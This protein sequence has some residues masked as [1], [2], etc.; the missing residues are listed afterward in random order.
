LEDIEAREEEEALQRH[1]RQIEERHRRIHGGV[2]E[3]EEEVDEIID[4]DDDGLDDGRFDDYDIQEN[5][6]LQSYIDNDTHTLDQ[7]EGIMDKDIL[8]TPEEKKKA[9]DQLI[10][11]NYILQDVLRYIMTN[12]GDAS[13]ILQNSTVMK[14]IAEYL[15]T[16]SAF[17]EK[18]GEKEEEGECD[19]ESSF[20]YDL[21]R[22]VEEEKMDGSNEFGKKKQLAIEMK[23]NIQK[24]PIK[25]I[26][27]RKK[28]VKRTTERSMRRS[29]KESVNRKKSVKRSTK[30]SVRR[31]TKRSVNRKK[32]V[33][34][35][36]KRS[37]NRKKSVKGRR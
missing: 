15:G 26:N 11:L 3:N 28:S 32:S 34:R 27:P 22:F 6:R 29:R 25:I 17:F 35:S 7:H 12:E 1:R 9:K 2:R 24:T 21:S 30:R 33:R 5:G 8:L 36:T 20:D 31:S 19:D 18:E 14:H 37:V 10:T 16:N 13:T 23:R 4:D